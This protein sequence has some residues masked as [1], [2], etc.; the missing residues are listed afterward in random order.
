MGLNERI[1]RATNASAG[2][3]GWPRETQLQKMVSC[4]VGKGAQYAN[5]LLPHVAAV[6]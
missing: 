1:M 2:A 5:I 3:R 6:T 4:I